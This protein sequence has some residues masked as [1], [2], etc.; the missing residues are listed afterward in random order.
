MARTEPGGGRKGESARHDKGIQSA[1][2]CHAYGRCDA[3]LKWLPVSDQSSLAI[4]VYTRLVKRAVRPTDWPHLYLH[5]YKPIGPDFFVT[6]VPG[7]S[8]PF[9]QTAPLQSA[10]LS[11]HANRLCQDSAPLGP[12][13]SARRLSLLEFCSLPCQMPR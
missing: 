13:V 7:Y 1:R 8:Y 4:R 3:L 2:G 11:I 5:F 10:A 12:A 6:H 9:L